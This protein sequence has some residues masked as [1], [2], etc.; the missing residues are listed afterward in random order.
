M[1]SHFS[2][3]CLFVTLWTVPHQSPLFME[4]SRQEY[5]S[6]LPWPP[7]GDLPHL[8]IELTS[9]RSPALTGGFFTTEPPGKPNIY[10]FSSVQFSCSVMSDS[11]QSRGLKHARLPCQ[12]PTP[13]ACS[14][15]CPSSQWCHPTISSSIVPFSSHPQSFPVSGSFQKSQFF[16]SGGQVLEF[17]L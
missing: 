14:N 8:G 1:L 15:S 10:Q 5:W 4:I 6:G 17:Q 7:P 2:L 3:V 11:L 9:L 12:S 13:G 16:A